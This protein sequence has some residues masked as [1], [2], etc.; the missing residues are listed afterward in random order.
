MQ[1]CCVARNN[2]IAD[3]ERTILDIQLSD[4]TTFAGSLKFAWQCVTP[5]LGQ[6]TLHTI[7]INDVQLK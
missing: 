5:V 4:C 2:N 6:G 3:C 1:N 7:T